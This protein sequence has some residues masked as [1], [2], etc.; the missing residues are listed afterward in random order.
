LQIRH[1]SSKYSGGSGNGKGN[2]R[3]GD[4][5]IGE[6]RL[7][8]EGGLFG[9]RILE[10]EPTKDWD[11]EG[12]E[13]PPS[14]SSFSPEKPDYEEMLEGQEWSPDGEAVFGQPTVEDYVPGQTSETE[15][16]WTTVV[17][18]KG[19]GA[20]ASSSM[21]DADVKYDWMPQEEI[22]PSFIGRWGPDG[23]LLKEKPQLPLGE[24]LYPVP[25]TFSLLFLL[26]S[27]NYLKNG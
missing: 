23:R 8:G 22:A 19:F 26:A 7:F 25:G 4:D 21:T 11:E 16:G 12:D 13:P 24:D 9:K 6:P 1:F 27:G 20:E 18:E 15:E 14:W 3:N 2:S 10:D 17:S 5:D